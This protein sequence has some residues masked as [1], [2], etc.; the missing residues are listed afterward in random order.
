MTVLDPLP[1]AVQQPYLAL[2]WRRTAIPPGKLPGSTAGR[3]PAA[4]EQS[5]GGGGMRPTLAAGADTH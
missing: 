1:L 3:M 2:E 4:T 5:G